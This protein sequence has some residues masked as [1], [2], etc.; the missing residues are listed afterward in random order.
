VRSPQV[1][2]KII[3]L[4]FNDYAIDDRKS[5]SNAPGIS[6][7]KSDEFLSPTPTRAQAIRGTA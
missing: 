6:D 4:S 3:D 5:L 1:D 7:R 2:I